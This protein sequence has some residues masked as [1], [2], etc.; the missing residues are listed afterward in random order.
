M[1]LSLA[2]CVFRQNYA[3]LSLQ[4]HGLSY[5]DESTTACGG[6]FSVNE[7]SFITNAAYRALTGIS[8]RTAHRDL[9]T[10]VERGR[11]KKLGKKER[12]DTRAPDPASSFIKGIDRHYLSRPGSTK[13]TLQHLWH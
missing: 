2:N 13:L 7:H 9:E 12:E 3:S 8:V 6:F 4:N 11:P 5:I 1:P 10:L